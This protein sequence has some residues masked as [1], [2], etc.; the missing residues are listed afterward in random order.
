MKSTTLIL[1][2]MTF[3]LASC[4]A[5]KDKTN[6]ELIQDMM[7]GPQIKAQEYDE[8]SGGQTVRQPDPHAIP[9][10]RYVKPEMQLGDAENLKN[11]LKSLTDVELQMKYENR[12]QEKYVIYCGICHG[13][14]GDGQGALVQYQN[15]RGGRLIVKDPPNLLDPTYQKYSDGRIYYV[16]T[17]GWGLMGNYSTQ[18]QDEN[19]RWAVVNYVRQLQKMQSKD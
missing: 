19:D 5:G 1:I 2:A 12:G 13:D 6:V 14:K 4:G 9:R 10:N 8:E 11:P 15:K 17:Y 7:R 16:I 3:V 18:I